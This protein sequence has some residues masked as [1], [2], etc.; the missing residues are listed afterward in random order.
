MALPQEQSVIGSLRGQRSTSWPA[1]RYTLWSTSEAPVYNCTAPY[2]SR[3]VARPLASSRENRGE[4]GE[5]DSPRRSGRECT[6][7]RVRPFRVACQVAIQSSGTWPTATR[8]GRGQ[9]LPRPRTAERRGRSFARHVLDTAAARRNLRLPW[10][11]AS[12]HPLPVPPR[13][14]SRL[15]PGVPQAKR[16][17]AAASPDSIDGYEGKRFPGSRGCRYDRSLPP[18]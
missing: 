1:T 15:E 11:R 9:P 12:P 13:Y 17:Q 5:P 4:H 8:S 2:S 7:G 18:R 6:D 16:R 3:W 14:R 10:C